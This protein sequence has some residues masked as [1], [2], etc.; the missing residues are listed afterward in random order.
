MTNCSKRR[1]A[2]TLNPDASAAGRAQ[3][4]VHHLRRCGELPDRV[5]DD[6]VLV[7]HELVTHSIHQAHSPIRLHVVL[8]DGQVMLRVQD[9]GLVSPLSNGTRLGDVRR[10]ETVKRLSASFGSHCGGQPRNVGTAAC[11]RDV[12]APL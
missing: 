7:V 6:A 1:G 11:A 8:T 5:V 4:L 2:L 9:A 10:W 3:R 12:C